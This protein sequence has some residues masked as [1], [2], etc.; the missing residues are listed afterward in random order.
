MSRINVFHWTS[1]YT[2]AEISGIALKM[3]DRTCLKE[4]GVKSIG[5]QLQILSLLKDLLGMYN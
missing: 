2:E 5:K 4:M 1:F 3:V